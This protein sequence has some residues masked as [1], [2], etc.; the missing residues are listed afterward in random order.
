MFLRQVCAGLTLGVVAL[1]TGCA[2]CGHHRSCSS[3]PA[4][5][6]AAPVPAPCCGA[7]GS[8]PAPPAAV[9]ATGAVYSSPVP[10]VPF[11]R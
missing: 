2:C 3:G 4:V 5:V 9:G 11:V 8:V 10:A 1:A 7:P 6:N